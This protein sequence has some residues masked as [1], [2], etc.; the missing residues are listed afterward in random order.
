M[1]KLG[2]ISLLDSLIKVGFREDNVIEAIF[3]FLP[4]KINWQ[5]GADNLTEAYF[6]DYSTSFSALQSGESEFIK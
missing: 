1:L 3:G 2:N 4:K 5:N 6:G